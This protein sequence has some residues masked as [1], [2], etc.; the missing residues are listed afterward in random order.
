MP[1]LGWMPLDYL[2]V[3]LGPLQDRAGRARRL[4]PTA[5]PR[6]GGNHLSNT[7][8]LTQVFFKSDE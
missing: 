5:K 6:S 3:T 7:T 1:D 8:C 4:A 2:C